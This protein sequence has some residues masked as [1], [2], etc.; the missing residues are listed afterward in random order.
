MTRPENQKEPNN[1][2]EYVLGF[3]FDNEHER[4][5]LIRKTKPA[6]QAGKLNGVGGKV[7]PM[8]DLRSA[9]LRE[10][11]EETGVKTNPMD[12]R[13]YARLHGEQFSVA[14][15]CMFSNLV[16]NKVRTVEDEKVEVYQVDL[17]FIGSQSIS[18]LPWLISLALDTDQPRIFVEAKYD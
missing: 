11:Y 12:W 1:F 13:F 10:F 8:E 3:C 6:W 15:F 5:V 7:E 14:V 2:Q 4:V 17:E 16:V 9:M 18:N